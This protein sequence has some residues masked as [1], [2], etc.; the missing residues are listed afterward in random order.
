MEKVLQGPANTKKPQ[1]Q[2]GRSPIMDDGQQFNS[3]GNVLDIFKQAPQQKSHPQQVQ[4]PEEPSRNN[5]LQDIFN[6][7]MNKPAMPLNQMDNVPRL[8]PNQILQ[9]IPPDLHHL[10]MNL[11][12][13]QWDYVQL[14][15]SKSSNESI[16]N[17]CLKVVI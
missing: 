9:M 13:S 10:V 6:N 2:P 11:N 7:M 3:G 1:M 17:Y 16:T 5:S 12:I 4:V 8:N 15:N 14:A